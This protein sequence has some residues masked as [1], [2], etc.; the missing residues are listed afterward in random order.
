MRAQHGENPD[1]FSTLIRA[2]EL[3]LMQRRYRRLMITNRK[4]FSPRSI[5]L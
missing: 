5:G 1:N 4:G 3:G 2:K